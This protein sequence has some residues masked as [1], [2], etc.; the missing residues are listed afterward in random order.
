M[1]KVKIYRFRSL[2]FYAELGM[3]RL[4]DNELEKDTTVPAKEFFLRAMS[5]RGQ[6][7]NSFQKTMKPTRQQNQEYQEVRKFF[8]DATECVKAARAQGDPLD[9]KTMSQLVKDFRPGRGVV[10]GVPS[11]PKPTKK[12][13]PGKQ[14][15]PD[16]PVPTARKKLIIPGV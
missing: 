8:F 1:A 4:K 15:T 7:E 16:G 11:M 12:F 13:D 6:E 10:P 3:I 9:P 2:E 14:V 5:L